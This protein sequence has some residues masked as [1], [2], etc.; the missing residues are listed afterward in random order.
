MDKTE[1][2]T[3]CN[4][5]CMEKQKLFE[6]AI[7]DAEL[8][9]IGIGEEFN[10]DFK[11]ISKFPRLMSVLEEVDTNPSLEWT[12]P[13]LEKIYLEG[14]N[15]GRII[16]AYKQLY[17]IVK[18]KNYYIVTTCIDENIEKAGFDK[19]RIVQPCGNYKML[20]CSDK[21]C[22]DLIDSQSYIKLVN[23]LTIDNVGLD[24]LERFECPRCKK[25]LAFNNILCEDKYVEEG[26]Q[27]QW[28]NYT[29][30]LQYTLNKKLCILELG[31]GVNL[32]NIIRWP[33]EK[34][35]FYNKKAS[36]FRINEALYQMTA[37][38][39]E[40][41]VSIPMN[42]VDFFSSYESIKSK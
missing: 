30:W 3:E 4:T 23:Q 36:F 42:A 9:L 26:Y 2:K 32:P 37:D 38:I 1:Q 6:D 14:H 20:Q 27:S 18:E 39:G 29:K 15:E 25:P 33:F 21:C 19:E 28:E 41:G 40:K 16:E 17:E 13:Y 12:V 24:S 22:V 5:S 8:V 10:E 31:V 35:A 11:D 7:K 34:I